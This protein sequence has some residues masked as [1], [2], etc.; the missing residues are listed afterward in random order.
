MGVG[1]RVGVGIGIEVRERGVKNMK[2]ARPTPGTPLVRKKLPLL[3]A[4]NTF[5]RFPISVSPISQYLRHSAK[6]LFK[7]YEEYKFSVPFFI[8]RKTK[9]FYFKFEISQRIRC[10]YNIHFTS[11]N[12]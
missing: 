6:L 1:V 10:L 8:R 3:S 9:H 7:F 4:N 5:Y 11:L 12:F 2:K